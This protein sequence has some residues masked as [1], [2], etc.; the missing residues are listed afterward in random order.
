[1]TILLF[2]STVDI[3]WSASSSIPYL[4]FVEELG[5][6]ADAVQHESYLM[7]PLSFY[8]DVVEAET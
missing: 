8:G 7:L 2:L 3:D 4:C 6:T 1:M 5:S